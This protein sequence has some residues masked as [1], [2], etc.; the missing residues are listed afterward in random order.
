MSK[1]H[2]QLALFGA[3]DQEVTNA[4]KCLA[5]GAADSDAIKY[6]GVI[7]MVG[8]FLPGTA[9][10]GQHG[11]YSELASFFNRP[12]VLRSCVGFEFP[13]ISVALNELRKAYVDEDDR[14]PVLARAAYAAIILEKIYNLTDRGRTDDNDVLSILRPALRSWTTG[15]VDDAVA[16]LEARIV[17]INNR[18]AWLTHVG[19]AVNT[20]FAERAFACVGTLKKVDGQYSAFI[21]TDTTDDEL[22]VGDLAKIVEPINWADCC[23]FFCKMTAQDEPFTDE[24]ATRV[25]E[26]ISGQCAEYFIDTALT[27]WKAEQSDGSIFINYDLDSQRDNDTGLVEVDSGY[28]WITPIPGRATGVRIRTSKLERVSGLS[29]T[30]TA[31][32]ASLLGWGNHAHEMLAGTAR[33]YMKNPV[34]PP[35]FQPF[36]RSPYDMKTY[37]EA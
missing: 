14:D 9:G 21:T 29:P 37:N 5:A 7:D 6:A 23:A 36:R 3:I 26:R 20:E 15:D 27:F 33:R 12:D 32:L 2:S 24:G 28:I 17:A 22:T 10:F 16:A 11:W 35:S 13:T 19:D 30:A 8:E 4:K 31:T 34:P 18:Q 25:S 1:L